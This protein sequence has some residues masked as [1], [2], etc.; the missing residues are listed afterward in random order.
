MPA[1][2]AVQFSGTDWCQRRTRTRSAARTR[3]LLDGAGVTLPDQTVTGPAYQLSGSRLR[4][5]RIRSTAA[6]TALDCAA[7]RSR[8]RRRPPRPRPT[9]RGPGARSC[10]RPRD[11]PVQPVRHPQ[12]HQAGRD[13]HE[14]EQR[15]EGQRDAAVVAGRG[16]RGGV[17]RHHGW[18]HEGHGAQVTSG[19]RVVARV[20][21]VPGPMPRRCRGARARP[22]TAVRHRDRLRRCSGHG[23]PLGCRSRHPADRPGGCMRGRRRT[24]RLRRR[25]RIG[26][27]R[28]CL[29]GDRRRLRAGPSGLGRRQRQHG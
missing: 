11:L 19:R 26:R 22:S 18:G 3:T 27:R 20:R 8:P 25:S 7:P 10:R 21:P 16:S 15:T 23:G 12:Q 9:P 14:Q 4:L 5:P 17:A 6:V 1:Q 29:G 28:G 24:V 13:Q 2:V